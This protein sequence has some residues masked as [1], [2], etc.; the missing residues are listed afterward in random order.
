MASSGCPTGVTDT[1]EATFGSLGAGTGFPGGIVSHRVTGEL[2]VNDQYRTLYDD[3]AYPGLAIPAGSCNWTFNPNDI[4]N[5]TMATHETSLWASN[6]NFGG[7][8]I[9]TY[10]QSFKGAPLA[11]AC[12]TP[13]PVGGPMASNV[14][15]EFLG[16]AAW[17]NRGN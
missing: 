8:P 1:Y 14:N 3:G 4:T 7:S 2:Y 9:Y 5:I 17:P 6:I 12:T 11:G 16:V 13:A 15:D 10:L